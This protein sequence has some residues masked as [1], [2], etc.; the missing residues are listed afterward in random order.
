MCS[1]AA[2]GYYVDRDNIWNLIAFYNTMGQKELRSLQLKN[3]MS[4]VLSTKL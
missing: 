1:S 2:D 4:E 3:N